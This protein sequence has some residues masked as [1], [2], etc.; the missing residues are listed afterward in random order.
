M[1]MHLA[2]HTNK[3]THILDTHNDYV[4]DTVWELYRYA[5]RRLGGVATL[6]EWDANI[7][8]FDIVHGEALKARQFREQEERRSRRRNWKRFPRMATE[9]GARTNPALDAGLHPESGHLRRSHRV[10]AAQSAIPADEAREMVLPS[11]TLSSLER[12]DIYRDMYLLRMEEALSIDYPSLKHFLGD[13]EFMRMVARYVD[14]YPSRSY[15]LNRLGDHL[16]EFIDTLDDLPQAGFLPGSGA[17]GIC[18]DRCF[19]CRET[20]P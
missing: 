18:A 15:T 5:H 8:G 4:I 6:L 17:P 3:G 7:P 20:P 16:C 2:G 1:Q 14:V 13:E 19:R 9:S 12:L 10:R 11:K